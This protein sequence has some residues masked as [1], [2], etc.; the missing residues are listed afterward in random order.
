MH[1]IHHGKDY[2]WCPECVVVECGCGEKLH[3]TNPDEAVC[4]CGQGHAGI[5]RDELEARWMR[6]GGDPP[7]REELR[8]EPERSEHRYW[9][10]LNEID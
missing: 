6:G 7:W 9:V 4:R 3:F 8:G 10:E 5:V 1:E 2:V